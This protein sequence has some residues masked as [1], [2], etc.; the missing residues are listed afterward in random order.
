MVISTTKAS[1]EKIESFIH[2]KILELKK[3]TGVNA[4]SIF[5]P[6]AILSVQK[7]SQSRLFDCPNGNFWNDYKMSG[8]K[9]KIYDSDLVS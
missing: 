2:V 6:V 9:C 8:E 1:G 5:R 7:S 4:T 3:K